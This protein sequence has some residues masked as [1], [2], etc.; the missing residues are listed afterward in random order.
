MNVNLLDW[1]SHLH[2]ITQGLLIVSILA[3]LIM[4]ALDHNAEG[5][6]T[7]LLLVVQTILMSSNQ[8]VKPK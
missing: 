3:L 5:N 6:V 7:N 8:I 4:I 1:F 2:P